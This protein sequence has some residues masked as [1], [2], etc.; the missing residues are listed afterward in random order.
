MPSDDFPSWASPS[1]SSSR[2]SNNPLLRATPS[3]NQAIYNQRRNLP[4]HQHLQQQQHPSRVTFEVRRDDE[5][6][7]QQ[8]YQP[9]SP[10]ARFQPQE[11][12]YPRTS[13][14][15]PYVAND[16]LIRRSQ[17]PSS[18]QEQNTHRLQNYMM[19][20]A[21]EQGVVTSPPVVS[22]P[23]PSHSPTSTRNNN[24]PTSSPE[25][26]RHLE[27]FIVSTPPRSQQRQREDYTTTTS[28]LSSS[29][30]SNRFANAEKLISQVYARH[31]HLL[32]TDTSSEEERKLDEELRMKYGATKVPIQEERPPSFHHQASASS[33]SSSLTSPSQLHRSG[34]S[35]TQI[36]K[37]VSLSSSLEKGKEVLKDSE[38]KTESIKSDLNMQLLGVQSQINKMNEEMEK[39]KKSIQEMSPIRARGSQYSYEPDNNADEDERHLV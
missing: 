9:E 39:W 2:S 33:S 35:A 10:T 36:Q 6:A 16:F 3:T 26:V 20:P 24:F 4:V 18:P 25:R 17:E 38:N 14:R 31:G 5:S 27:Q 22:S 29:S 7:S 8:Q 37:I 19:R 32:Q 30:I 21:V 15:D 13:H 23:S 12:S 11:V 28:S 1:P 34:F